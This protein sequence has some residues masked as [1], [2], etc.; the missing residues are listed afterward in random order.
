MHRA[1]GLAPQLGQPRRT[2]RGSGAGWPQAF[3][4]YRYAYGMRIILPAGTRPARGSANGPVT[5]SCRSMSAHKARVA[6]DGRY[7]APERGL[8]R[9]AG[10]PSDVYPLGCVLYELL[11]GRPPFQGEIP[12]AVVYQHV[13]V[14]PAPPGRLRPGLPG[15]ME[16]YLLRLLTKEPGRRPTLEQT[17]GWFA[18]WRAEQPQPPL[19]ADS[20]TKTSPPSAAPKSLLVRGVGAGRSKVLAGAAGA[21]VF[22]VSVAVGMTM[23]SDGEYLS[24][25]PSEPSPTVSGTSS[26]P[27]TDP[28]APTTSSPSA[29]P[30]TSAP[31][32]SSAPPSTG[33][34]TST[35]PSTKP[36]VRT[37][38]SADQTTAPSSV[39]PKK[40][41]RKKKG[42]V[43]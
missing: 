35:S 27:S 13:D 3:G 24:S 43:H 7:L 17:A 15:A 6:E 26:P 21:V 38:A 20:R 22:A 40:P 33:Q 31:A 18:A 34:R 16:E 32:S 41:E 25:R 11:T 39:P 29:S 36:T 14:P 19:R 28:S 1:P 10:P 4:P 2:W 30:A 42:R 9:P 23:N 5:F 12:T 37:T 8:G